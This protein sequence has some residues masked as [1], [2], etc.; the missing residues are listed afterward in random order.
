MDVVWANLRGGHASSHRELLLVERGRN[1]VFEAVLV[2]LMVVFLTYQYSD[3][4]Y[5]DAWG[6][7]HAARD[8][9]A[10]GGPAPGTASP[11]VDYVVAKDLLREI[12]GSEGLDALLSPAAAPLREKDGAGSGSGSGAGG[13]SS[14][15]SGSSSS[16]GMYAAFASPSPAA[17]YASHAAGLYSSSASLA[18]SGLLSPL[19]R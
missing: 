12:L 3:E 6:R 5:S 7:P 16:A 19:S 15:S 1:D 14:S 17:A 9:G 2:F 11:I 10:G 18:A 13:A 4:D 8:R